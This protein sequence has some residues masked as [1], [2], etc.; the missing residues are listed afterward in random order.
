MRKH[1][2]IGERVLKAAPALGQVAGLVRSTHEHWD[3]SGYPDGLAG[4][5]I[6]LGA[7]IILICDAYTAMTEGRPYKPAVGL[8]KA[9]EV[10][11]AGAGVEF[12]PGLVRAFA[13]CVQAAPAPG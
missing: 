2:L 10:L 8:G 12:D 1:T 3:G 4:T 6:P 5:E 9:L 7:R 11:R 13:E